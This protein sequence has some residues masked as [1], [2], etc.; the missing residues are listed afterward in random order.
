M[1][2]YFSQRRA[3]GRSSNA[4]QRQ[5]P[6]VAYAPSRSVGSVGRFGSVSPW[7]TGSAA[8]RAGATKGNF[9]RG[10]S[11]VTSIRLQRSAL[12]RR[13]PSR[14]PVRSPVRQK[15]HLPRFISS[16]FFAALSALPDRVLNGSTGFSRD[17]GSIRSR[18]S[19][20]TV[21]LR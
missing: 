5:E 16:S 13:P 2:R 10:A 1:V 20:Y 3:C 12:P 11:A 6:P 15:K 4:R 14:P 7:S 21:K 19:N 17:G 9:H 18:K 8:T